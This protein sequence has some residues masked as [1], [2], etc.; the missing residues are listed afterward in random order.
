MHNETQIQQ[1][2]SKQMSDLVK[3]EASN[4]PAENQATAMM[5]IISRA[6]ADPACDLDKM[7]RLLSMKE[8]IDK[9]ENS[10]QFNA[11]M[12]SMQIEMPSVAE[13][14]TGHNIKYATFEDINDVAKPIMSKY[15]FAV[16]F[17]VVETDKGVRV[18]GLLLHR[19]GH[20]E[21]TEMTFPSDTSGSKNAVQAIGSS[22]SYA[23]RY[24][25]CAM[26]NI[27]TRGEDDNGFAAVPFAPITAMQAQQIS[28]LLEKCKEET[29]A[30]FVERFGDPKDTPKSEFN[31]R[32]AQVRS[33]HARDNA[34]DDNG[35]N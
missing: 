17:K 24:I 8:R 22:I 30:R 25:M 10:R 15:G 9:E 21:E 5:Q 26:L 3:Q 18:T 1:T 20:R 34:G 4:L 35:N 13:R 33:A 14:G 7:E 16:S 28:S 29:Q 23:K 11:D 6:A 32:L 2:G 27:T 19:S 12:A 31:E